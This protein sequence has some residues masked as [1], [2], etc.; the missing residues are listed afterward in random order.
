MPLS[1][2][3]HADIFNSTLDSVLIF[4]RESSK[5]HV[6]LGNYVNVQAGS[7]KLS[8]PGYLIECKVF[9]DVLCSLKTCLW[10]LPSLSPFYQQM[11][12]GCLCACVDMSRLLPTSTCTSAWLLLAWGPWEYLWWPCCPRLIWGSYC[13]HQCSIDNDTTVTVASLMKS[14]SHLLSTGALINNL[15]RKTN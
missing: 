2:L 11:T 15:G 12:V 4:H 9:S 6:Y 5:F 7:P 8:K 13:L 10:S 3:A 14:A 1:F